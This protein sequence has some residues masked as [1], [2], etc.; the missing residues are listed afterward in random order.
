MDT[1]P[2]LNVCSQGQRRPA[3]V[4]KNVIVAGWS[5]GAQHR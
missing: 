4:T 3:I 2:V 1:F 5:S